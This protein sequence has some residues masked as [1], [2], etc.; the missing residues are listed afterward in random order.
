MLIDHFKIV[1]I[2]VEWRKMRLELFGSDEFFQQLWSFQAVA[3]SRKHNEVNPMIRKNFPLITIP[4][5]TT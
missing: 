1:R 5:Q 2:Y 4:Q 3:I